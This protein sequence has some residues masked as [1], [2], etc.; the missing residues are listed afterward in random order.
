MNAEP[1][2]TPLDRLLRDI[3]A[4]TRGVRCRRCGGLPSVTVLGVRIQ[5]RRACTNGA[6]R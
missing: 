4:L 6:A 3:R 5:H 1:Y 2:L